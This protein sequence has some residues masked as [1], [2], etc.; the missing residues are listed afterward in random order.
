MKELKIKNVTKRLAA[1]VL[2]AMMMLSGLAQAT[3]VWAE[4][5]E[6]AATEAESVNTESTETESVDA[7]SVATEN[8]YSYEGDGYAVTYKIA[9]SWNDG[10]T[11]EV[12]IKNTGDKKI[13]NW[14]LMFS[15]DGEIANIWNAKISSRNDDGM[16]TV[17][18]EE[19]NAN[20][21]PNETVTFGFNAASG[22]VEIPELHFS[23]SVQVPVKE[24]DFEVD[25]AV[26]DD[27]ETGFVGEIG[28]QNKSAKCLKDWCIAFDWENEIDNIW[29]AKI[30]S[31]EEKHYVISCEEYNRNIDAGQRVQFGFSCSSGKSSSQPENIT[32]T[33]FADGD[34][35]DEDISDVEEEIDPSEVTEYADIEYQ[36]GNCAE[37]VLDDVQFM[38]Y[39]PE[40]LDVTWVSSDESV[41]TNEGHV[42]RGQEDRTATITAKIQYKGEEYQKEFVLTVKRITDIDVSTLQDYSLSQLDEM[43][44][45]DEDYEVDV[46]DYRYLESIYGT[47][48][49]VKVDSYETALVSLYNVKS[50]IGISN[51]FD[52]LQIVSVYVD[53]AGYIFRFN[54]IYKGVQVQDNHVTVSTDENGKVDF[55]GSSYFPLSNDINIIP[56][57][58][59][60]EAVHSVE[61]CGYILLEE[62]EGIQQELPVVFNEYGIGVLVWNL[63][64]RK[65]D[66]SEEGYEVYVD[67]QTGEA[68]FAY[69]VSCNLSNPDKETAIGKDMLNNSRIFPV[70]ILHTKDGKKYRLASTNYKV[71]VYNK[72][73]KNPITKDKNQWKKEEVSAM[74]NMIDIS[75][76]YRD[77]F[78]RYSYINV[79]KRLQA[80]T[81]LDGTVKVYF[82]PSIENNATWRK[83]SILIGEGTGG[84]SGFKKRSLAAGKDILAHEF[85]HGIISED[86][87]M[88]TTGISGTVNEAYADILAC[89]IDSN[90][91]IGEDMKKRQI[92]MMLGKKYYKL[93]K[94]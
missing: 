1:A 13:H 38:N 55:L 83:G 77:T 35:K 94:N 20:I 53:E 88:G 78:D 43:N 45:G 68:L 61:E 44:S 33:H 32:V 18:G 14:N 28:I 49:D 7:D 66:D 72:N 69:K 65:Q 58:T 8:A 37:S 22:K 76:Y 74:A 70:Q 19:Y 21:K 87:G 31:H 73:N 86:T 12:S 64:C 50:A 6:N 52:E 46:N 48:S 51:P 59:R 47:Y 24:T 10:Y 80:G 62:V 41:V 4:E 23:Q 9:N 90:W 16:Y 75:R 60:E 34:G 42:T 11:A 36:R 91:T 57:I 17:E 39:A 81:L 15:L 89:Y 27:W 79:Q 71:E 56:Q 85:T 30:V 92:S 2:S 84:Q 40:L 29:N 54:Q 26:S 5:T 67:A 82:D 63:F 3:P 25:Y 93:H